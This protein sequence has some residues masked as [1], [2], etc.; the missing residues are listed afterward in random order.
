[1]ASVTQIIR[2]RRQ[3]KRYRTERQTSRRAWGFI[4]GIVAAVVILGPLTIL[5]GGVAGAY[6]RAVNTIPEPRST[7]FLDEIVGPTRIYDSTGT[8]LLFTVEDPLGT[9][10]TWISLDD[11]PDYIADATILWEDANFES[12]ANFNPFLTVSRLWN[13]LLNGP[14][15]VQHSLTGR[16]VRNVITSSGDFVTIEQRGLEIALIAEVNRRYSA[17]E[18]LEWHLNTNYYGNEAY[19]IEA[20]AQV[21]LGK[22]ARDLT[23]DEAALLATI[24]T[25]PNFNPVDAET[26]ARGR[27]ADLLRRMLANGYITQG[28][29]QMASNTQ[30]IIRT[31]AGQTPE[32]AP[33][34]AVY[35]RRQAENILASLG[36][37]GDQ[38]VARGGLR[39]TTTLDLD[40][41]YQAECALRTHLARLAGDANPGLTALD[42]SP[43]VITSLLPIVS[44]DAAGNNPPSTGT[45]VIIDPTTGE[46]SAMIGPGSRGL[47]QPGPVLHP[48]VYLESFINPDPNFTAASML[49]DIPRSF[50]GSAD[51]LLYIPNN[52]DEQFRGPLSLRKAMGA[53]LLPPVTQVANVLN[54]NTVLRSTAH[55]LGIN[56]LQDGIYD[57]SLLERGGAVTPL[58]VTYAYS[59][60]ASMG[61]VTGIRVDPVA[62][63][64]R[65]HDPAAVRRIETTDGEILWEY[66]EEHMNANRVPLLQSELAF[67][68]NDVLSDPTT[69]WDTL[70]RENPL[71]LS[72]R[73]AI[74]QGITGD[75]VDNWTIGYTP[76]KAVGVRMGRTGGGEMSLRGFGVEGA[77]PVWHAVMEYLHQ[78]DGL[79]DSGWSRPQTM[80]ETQVCEISGLRPNGSCETRTEIFLDASRFPR[81]DTYWQRVEINTQT[82]QLATINTPTA[83]RSSRNYFIPPDEA[84]DWWRANNRPLPPTQ[85]DTISRPDMLSSAVILQPE[86]FDIVGGVVDVR[87]SMDTSEMIYYQLSYGQGTNPDRWIDIT[88]Q[89]ES[90]TPG[91]SIGQ[92]DTAGLEGTYIIRLTVV[93]E[94][95]SLETGTSQVIVDNI[96]PTIILT[97][98]EP[99]QS[100]RWPEDQTIPIRAEV[101]DNIRIDR[102]EFYHNGQLIGVDTNHPYGYDHPINRTGTEIFTA[103]VFDAVGNSSEAEI[104]VEVTRSG[105]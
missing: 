79:P 8:R 51:G 75:R 90:F 71:E 88:G 49:L 12:S 1:M 3:R 72:R 4:L 35:A 94:D 17:E 81:E 19:G 84:M 54:L 62:P 18:I 89:R 70:G 33:E 13:N 50:P 14:L 16:L 58:D 24:P 11:L 57:L 21:Y 31:D 34:F 42:G 77:G 56:T 101:V 61:Q 53:G 37:D 76:N 64:F 6:I 41:Y 39:I 105:S 22:S 5:V 69:R 15:E 43:C 91:T 46:L 92:W 82:G 97:A 7:I 68:V 48:F 9:D 25:A 66:G 83:L 30:T 80:A 29:F 73:A 78:R 44:A 95:G 74:V 60:F 28:Q 40:L 104:T 96:P 93:M 38:M 2:R 98:G 85:S 102:V 86:N 32:V 52:P 27:Q 59:V 26:A 87:G 65:S 99:G 23:L 63:G 100:F 55:P 47:Y 20:A 67:L 10:R 45:I 36:Q 103:V